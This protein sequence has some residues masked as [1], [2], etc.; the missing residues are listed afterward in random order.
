MK[1]KEAKKT[2]LEVAKERHAA[3]TQED[4]DRIQSDWNSNRLKHLMDLSE[5]IGSYRDAN[6]RELASLLDME[7][8]AKDSRAFKSDYRRAKKYIEDKIAQETGLARK[9]MKNPTNAANM[10]DLSEA[11]GIERGEYMTFFEANLLRGNPN[12]ALSE[13]YRNNCQTCVVAHEL[14]RRGFNVEAL[15]NT[16]GSW[17]EKLSRR[18][19]EIWLDADG[20]IPGKT[21]IGAEYNYFSGTTPDGRRFKRGWN[22]TV[23][24]RRQLI[25]KLESSIT[26]DGRYHIQWL[27]NT[28]SKRYIDGHIITLEKIGDTLRYYDPQ[29]GKAIDNFY[30]YIN[31]IMLARGISVLRVDNLRVNADYASHILGKSRSR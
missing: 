10:E 11:L 14:R 16:E 18:T 6:L 28:Q 9:F 26:E 23:A 2:A 5:R 25:R 8:A 27:W 4:I 29:N 19:N 22:K 21:I 17:L 15:A 20:N 13:A 7:N 3:R 1:P 12:Y 31:D 30:D 24:N